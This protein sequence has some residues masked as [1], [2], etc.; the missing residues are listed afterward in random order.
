MLNNVTPPRLFVSYSWTNPTHIGWV[1]QLAT[2]LR[3]DGIDVILDKWDLKE[4][5]DSDFFMEQMVSNPDVSKV[6]IVCDKAYVEKA[7][8]RAG[9]VGTEAQII[10]PAL[11]ERTEQSKFV[12]L[13]TERD[14]RGKL[15]FQR[16][17]DLK[18]TSTFRTPFKI[19]TAT[20]N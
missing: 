15:S 8:K 16:I 5:Y 4:G 18:F 9:G 19:L 10:S 11:Y 14:Q 13:V 1:I 2:N 3:S 7:N 20:S 12:A 6:I 17:M